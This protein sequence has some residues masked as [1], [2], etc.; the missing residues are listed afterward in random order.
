MET[1]R[2]KVAS[3]RGFEPPRRNEQE[4]YDLLR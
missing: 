1:K 3:L 2:G 4:A